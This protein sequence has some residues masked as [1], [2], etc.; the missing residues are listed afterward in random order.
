MWDLP[1]S[2]ALARLVGSYADE[3][4]FVAAVCHG[5]A[6]LVSARRHDGSPVVAGCKVNGFT[7]SEVRGAKARAE[8]S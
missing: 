3:G 6:G 5:P 2:G 7:N 1:A 4:R 8:V